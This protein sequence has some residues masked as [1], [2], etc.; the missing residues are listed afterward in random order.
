MEWWS[1]EFLVL[2]SG[3]LPNPKLETAVMSICFNTY[4]FAFMFPMGLGAAARYSTILVHIHTI[5]RKYCTVVH[6]Y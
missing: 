4:V 6:I 5:A 2:L 1:F 3:L